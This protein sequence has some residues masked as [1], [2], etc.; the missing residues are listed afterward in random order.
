MNTNKR[1][2]LTGIV[3]VAIA[4]AL[5]VVVIINVKNAKKDTDKTAS[6]GQLKVEK[7]I[8]KDADKESESNSEQSVTNDAKEMDSKESTDEMSENVTTEK[9]TE[10]QTVEETTTMNIE[11]MT[12]KMYIISS[13]NVRKGPGMSE[14]IIGKLEYGQEITITGKYDEW[15]Q[16]SYNNN[17]AYVHYSLVSDSKPQISDIPENNLNSDN[18]ILSNDNYN[19]SNTGN[20]SSSNTGTNAG[21][22]SSSNTGANTGNGNNSANGSTNNGN[23]NNNSQGWNLGNWGNSN[24]NTDTSGYIDEVIRLVNEERAKQGLQPLKKNN[25]LCKVAGVRA[26]EIVNVFDH[27]RPDGRDCFSVLNDYNIK[28]MAVGENI[29]GGQSNPEA[30]MYSW[31]N[32]PGH[33]SNILS[34]SF[35]QIGI[36]FVKGK[37]AYGTYWVQIF[38]D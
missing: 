21:N 22:G 4:I 25:D 3:V 15:Y 34:E 14:K 7:N 23:Q 38:T 26:E 17:I 29:A 2:I 5:I 24:N 1:R 13:A 36:G 28:Y 18:G 20:G 30:V 11:Q 19:S 35:G 6:N 10:E 8:E 9:I 16:F 32:S 31:M 27:T 37:G 12:K 33:R